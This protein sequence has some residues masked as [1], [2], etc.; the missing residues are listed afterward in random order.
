MN[1]LPQDL[2][3]EDALIGIV[4]SDHTELPRIAGSISSEDFYKPANKLIWESLLELHR[5]G[6]PA[7]LLLLRDKLATKRQLTQIGG[8]NRLSEYLTQVYSSSSG[9]YYAE[10]VK[11]HSIG[12]QALKLLKEG[13]DYINTN[14]EK[15]L[16]IISKIQ[17]LASQNNQE[18]STLLSDTFLDLIQETEKVKKPE[19]MARFNLADLDD[20]LGYF[21]DGRLYVIAGRAGTGKTTIAINMAISNSR[22]IHKNKKVLFFSLESKA[23]DVAKKVIANELGLNAKFESREWL[24]NNIDPVLWEQVLN[25]FNTR[26]V[27]EYTNRVDR[28]ISVA[29]KEKSDLIIVDHIHHMRGDESN[30]V[31]QV[32][33]IVTK[34]KGLALELDTPIIALAQMNRNI[35]QRGD[36]A[37]PI[38]SD[39]KDAGAIE[40]VADYVVALHNRWNPNFPDVIE[41]HVLKHRYGEPN[42]MIPLS[43]DFAKS[44]YGDLFDKEPYIHGRFDMGSDSDF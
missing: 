28:I 43:Y 29:K 14:F 22:K 42:K 21:A 7:D 17:V 26:I 18:E 41:A 11:K 5:E 39:I 27:S 31:Q 16:E 20:N 12:R 3:A 2:D 24:D 32:A 35:L 33:N 9:K 40:E 38:M 4:L 8:A 36:R 15:S 1:N 19:G 44:K 23:T 34:L 10:I 30:R 13:S 37:S 6:K 25:D